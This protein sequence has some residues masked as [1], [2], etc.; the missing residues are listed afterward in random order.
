V[1]ISKSL[2]IHKFFK[3]GR[4]CLIKEVKAIEKNN[5]LMFIMLS[6][7]RRETERERETETERERDRERERQRERERERERERGRETFYFDTS[8]SI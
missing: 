2:I 1:E 5:R 3:F 4:S 7:D 8:I 6:H